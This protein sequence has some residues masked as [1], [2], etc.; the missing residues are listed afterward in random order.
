MNLASGRHRGQVFAKNPK[1]KQE[2][3]LLASP[4]RLYARSAR[5]VRGLKVIRDD[6]IRS[7]MQGST[8]VLAGHMFLAGVGAWRQ[9]SPTSKGAINSVSVDPI[10]GRW[11]PVLHSASAC[12]AMR[13]TSAGADGFGS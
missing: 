5:F 9:L 13:T 10:H 3:L 12:A 8:A 1:R 2:V 4:R 11:R 7:R 6:E